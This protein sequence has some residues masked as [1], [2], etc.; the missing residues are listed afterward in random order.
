MLYKYNKQKNFLNY[1]VIMLYVYILK[2]IFF[3][4]LFLY[5]IYIWKKKKDYYIYIKRKI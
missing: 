1:N 3:V 5:Y 4:Y 2:K